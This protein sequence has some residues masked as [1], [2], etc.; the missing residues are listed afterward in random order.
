MQ[1]GAKHGSMRKRFANRYLLHLSAESSGS[2]SKKRQVVTEYERGAGTFC[3]QYA[4]KTGHEP[5]YFPL[6]FCC[7]C[8]MAHC[9]DLVEHEVG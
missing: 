5:Q 9:A 4:V 2:H 1:D 6:G 8:T 7:C 3:L